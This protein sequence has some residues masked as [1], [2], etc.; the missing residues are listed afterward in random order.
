MCITR[1][2]NPII[3]LLAV[4]LFLAPT[5]LPFAGGNDVHKFTVNLTRPAGALDDDAHGMLRL[6]SQMKQGRHR[7]D[8]KVHDV[9][10]SLAHDL[11]IED[12]LDPG[13]LVFAGTLEVTG[14]NSVSFKVDTKKGDAL[15]LSAQDVLAYGGCRVEIRV[16]GQA[17]LTCTV[18]GD[19][20]GITTQSVNVPVRVKIPLL[21]PSVNAPFPKMKGKLRMRSYK[22]KSM[23]RFRVQVRR[24]PFED[25]TFHIFFE[26]T[27][28][29][30]DFVEVGELKRRRKSSRGRLR[31]NTRRGDAMPM[32][33]DYLSELGDR[34][35]QVRDQD[36]LVYLEGLIPVF[37]G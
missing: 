19:H 14:G 4:L 5:A 13:E 2:S 21:P 32:G 8:L 3:R 7:L 11:F 30:G 33:V 29:G 36:D 10:T 6:H 37:D 26:Q 25:R 23:Q 24:A 17:V 28:G 34:R 12:A 20:G 18:P 22:K 35:V 16:A 15:P 9:D 1:I 27:A 31:L